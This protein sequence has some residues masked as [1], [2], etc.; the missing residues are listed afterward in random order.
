M[1][2][3]KNKIPP[4]LYINNPEKS[5]SIKFGGDSIYDSSKF[6]P[7]PEN[8]FGKNSNLPILKRFKK[9]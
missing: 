1:R 7:K 5:F 3:I 2:N 6:E 4:A 8:G 9:D